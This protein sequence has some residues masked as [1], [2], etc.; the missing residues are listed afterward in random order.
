MRFLNGFTND[1]PSLNP[2]KIH[3]SNRASSNGA[4]VDSPLAMANPRH[5]PDDWLVAAPGDY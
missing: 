5:L 3:Q 2:Q 4:A 1:C